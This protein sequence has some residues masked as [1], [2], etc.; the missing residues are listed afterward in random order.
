M[1]S[2]SIL[3]FLANSGLPLSHSQTNPY[4]LFTMS[5]C[6]PA[7][8]PL[9]PQGNNYNIQPNWNGTINIAPKLVLFINSNTNI[10]LSNAISTSVDIVGQGSVP[11]TASL[12][13]LKGF[14][15]YDESRW[16]E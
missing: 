10:T 13:T 15:V 12:V 1:A 14:L 4:N 5:Q 7:A 9:Y 3:I 16:D 11:N 6:D 8:C 2:L